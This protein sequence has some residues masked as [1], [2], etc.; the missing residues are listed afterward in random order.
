MYVADR[1]V[2]GKEGMLGD[3]RE[4]LPTVWIAAGCRVHV[5]LVL[6]VDN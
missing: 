2:G 5:D 6:K 3:L 4:A 1:E